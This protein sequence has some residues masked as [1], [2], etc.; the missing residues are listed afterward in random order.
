M[1]I[2]FL[3]IY[4]NPYHTPYQ[5][6]TIWVPIMYPFVSHPHFI[7]P[8]TIDTTIANITWKRYLLKYS[9][10]K[11]LSG[12]HSLSWSVC[13]VHV[14][15]INFYWLWVGR[16]P[17]VTAG[18]L[19][20]NNAKRVVLRYG[21]NENERTEIKT[22]KLTLFQELI[23]LSPG[24]RHWQRVLC[25][26]VAINIEW[27]WRRW[28]INADNFTLPRSLSGFISWKVMYT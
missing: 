28:I 23:K 18:D 3:I 8:P 27:W 22:L 9:R 7:S 1:A 4:D 25:Y 16:R 20:Y 26:S 21:N 17:T 12:F 2:H 13:P 11:W 24:Q 19:Q 6:L 14:E 10:D 5:R 15:G